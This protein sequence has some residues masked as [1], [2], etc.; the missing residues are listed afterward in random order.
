MLPLSLQLGPPRHR[1]RR[2]GALQRLPGPGAGGLPPGAAVR[3]VDGTVEVK[4]PDIGDFKD[5]AVIELLVKP[6]DTVKVEQSLITVESDKASMEIPS[7]HAG[8]VKEMKVKLGDKV[9]EGSVILRS[10]D[11]RCCAAARGTA[12]AQR[13]LA[14]GAAAGGAAAPRRRRTGAPLAAPSPRARSAA[15]ASAGGR[16]RMRHA[17]ARRRPRRLLR[18]VPRRRPRHEGRAGRALRDARRRLPERRLH[19]VE[20]AAARRRGDGRG[21]ATSRRSASSF[22]KPKVDLAKLRAHKDKVVGKLTGGLA[23][24]AKMRKVT[25]VQRRRRVRRSAP[26]RGARPRRDGKTGTKQTIRF[27]QRDH[28]R[29]L[30]GG[31]AAVHAEGRPAHRRLR[32]ARSS[33]AQQPE[34]HADHRRRHHRPRDGH[35]VLDA[36]RAPRRGRD[37]RRPDA[38][39]RPRPGA[40]VAEDERAA[41][42]QHHAEDQDRRRR[43]DARTASCVQLRRRAAR[44]RS[45]SSTTWCCRRSA[46]APNGKRSAPRRP[47]STVSDR[48]FIPVDIQMRTN[49]PHIFA[50]RRHRRPADAG[51]QGGA[52]GARR[53][54]GRGRRA[55]GDEK[56]AERVRRARDPERRLHRSRGR[57]GRPDRGRGQGA[58]ASRSRRACSR[59]PRRAARSPTAATKASPSCCS[60]RQTPPHRRRRHRRHARRRH[61]RRDRAGDR[62]GRRRG[63]HRQDDPSA[64]DARRD[65]RHGRRGV[66]RRLHRPAAGR[67]ADRAGRGVRRCDQ[68]M[69]AQWSRSVLRAGR[70]S[71]TRA[72]FS[73]CERRA[74]SHGISA[75]AEELASIDSGPGAK[76][77][78]S[79]RAR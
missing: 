65:H 66:R 78:S 10:I 70:R 53:G 59:G 13:L 6:G 63:R 79:R 15:G 43:G 27:T 52:R 60:T 5:V 37:A 4:V 61:D 21:R 38:G 48:G 51:A 7:S 67:A 29:R 34:A 26:R 39:R 25:V 40:G 54:R 62:D 68:P 11:G 64:P 50:D 17:G 69:S 22:G 42:R 20:G 45:R 33:C 58:A 44:P 74:R 19:P 8:V 12:A 56:L 31:E 76:S 30:A 41:L 73:P 24:M 16:P 35:G 72:S 23:A 75:L 49:V 57:L 3:R 1:R 36:R 55:V 32:P 77:V 14:A 46:A 47:A 18:R 71:R 28:R 9:S 2:R